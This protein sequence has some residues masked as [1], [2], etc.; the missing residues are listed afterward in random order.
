MGYIFLWI[1]KWKQTLKK[2]TC[3]LLVLA[4]A[5]HSKLFPSS[6]YSHSLLENCQYLVHFLS[7][8]PCS[9]RGWDE[10]LLRRILLT[11]C[12]HD[13]S[14]PVFVNCGDVSGVCLLEH[15]QPFRLW[16]PGSLRHV[17]IWTT[18]LRTFILQLNS[19]SLPWLRVE[20]VCY[21]I[22]HPTINCL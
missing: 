9:G 20:R 5:L 16:Q 18:T 10:S 13:Y 1:N 4:S 12:F 6:S 21:Q 19:K 7:M 2:I 22:L 17:N 11:R 15:G 14:A 3:T 8:H